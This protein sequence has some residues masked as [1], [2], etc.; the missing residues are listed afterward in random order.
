MAV[1]PRKDRLLRPAERHRNPLRSVPDALI[2]C[3]KAGSST[4]Y[5]RPLTVALCL[6][7]Q[8][9][10]AGPADNELPTNGQIVSGD[11]AISQSGAAMT[12]LQNSQKMI[13]DWDT[14]NIGAGASVT[15]RQPDSSAVALN[16]VTTMGASHI[17]G[18]LNANG[19][20]FLV[21]PSGVTFAPGSRVDVGGITASSLNITD[22][23]F[24]TKSFIFTGDETSGEVLNQGEISAGYV[25]LI[26]PRVINEGRIVTAEGVTALGAGDQ[27]S[28]D[29]DGDQLIRLTVERSTVETLAAN[30]SLIRA[31]NGTVFMNAGARNSL[32]QAVVNNEGVI[33][34]KGIVSEGGR[35]LLSA[36][37]TAG[38]ANVSGVLD[39]SSATDKGGRI[40]VTGENTTLEST[41]RLLADGAT[42]GGDVL[43]GGSWQNSDSSVAQ[44]Q[45][46]IIKKGAVLDASAT[47]VGDGGTVV[48]WSDIHDEESA[49]FAHGTFKA[50]GGANG[51]DGGRI[52][53][54]GYYLS[55]TGIDLSA[56]APT[57]E[58]RGG[59]WLLDPYSLKVNNGGT[60]AGD[61]ALPDYTS[62]G[63]G[64]VI[65]RDDIEAQLDTGTSVTLQTGGT[66]GDG[67]GSGA[68]AIESSITKNSG[69]EATLRLNAHGSITIDSR[70]SSNS[71]ALN[72]YLNS[73]IEDGSGKI[74]LRAFGSV[75]TNG[76]YFYAYGGS[77]GTG[78][79]TGS[80]AASTVGF[81]MSNNRMISTDGGDVTIMGQGWAGGGLGILL[82]DGTAIDAG[83]GDIQLS[84]IGVD[85]GMG[86]SLEAMTI[87]TSG[88]GKITLTGSHT[89]GSG[90]AVSFDGT[91]IT[92]VSGDI[93]L[94]ADSYDFAT[95][96]TITSTAGDLIIATNNTSTMIGINDAGQILNLQ[97]TDLSNVSVASVQVGNSSNT[98]GIS[99][100]GATT[101]ANNLSLVTGGNIAIDGSLDVGSNE[102]AMTTGGN[103]TQTAAVTAAGL[104]LSGGG[105]YTLTDAANNVDTLAADSATTLTYV[106][107][108]GVTVGTVAGTEGVTASGDV[109][110][111]TQA[112]NI[113]LE[114]SVATS[115]TTASALTIHA[116]TTAAALTSTGGDVISSGGTVSV[117]D[118]G[119]GIIYTGSIGGSSALA[120][121]GNFRYSTDENHGNFSK[122]LG[123]GGTY[124]LYREQPS[125]TI[126]PTGYESYEGSAPTPSQ[127]TA[128]AAYNG[129]ILDTGNTSASIET[130]GTAASRP[131]EVF[132]LTVSG[133]APNSYNSLGYYIT[134][135][136][137]NINGHSI[138]ANPNHDQGTDAGK[139]VRDQGNGLADPFQLPEARMSPDNTLIASS[140]YENSTVVLLDGK[141]GLSVGSV[142]NEPTPVQVVVFRSGAAPVSE[143]GFAVQENSQ[144]VRLEPI[145]LKDRGFLLPGDISETLA[146]NVADLQGVRSGFVAKIT[147]GGVIIV[148][149]NARSRTLAD[150]RR[151]LVIQT[152]LLELREQ[153][154][155]NI[156]S[157]RTVY[158]DLQE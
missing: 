123:S 154:E 129:D 96:P 17:H 94:K 73:G 44:A 132:D 58:G 86:V 125:V 33:E 46:T 157:L 158:I 61:T 137:T 100:G 144:S 15:F 102:L 14:F 76:G 148:P 2:Y 1:S 10:L 53:T 57:S 128:S 84:G 151:D 109:N 5:V 143:K 120:D 97:S 92:T 38:E 8:P 31:E 114:K 155:L 135:A 37:G 20:V 34:A 85:N 25:A 142:L 70:I 121:T 35:I 27:V 30:R 118:G 91:T 89:G 67:K 98:G 19:Q 65:D 127:S 6:V 28:L 130:L 47:D 104:K 50:E 48:A 75:A 64:T 56:S 39:V 7:S 110:I 107:A 111:S 156:S 116:G 150:G 101:L 131:G 140:V 18:S 133:L 103:V 82:G 95:S 108:D 66:D 115:G 60:T 11:G 106:N 43:V 80:S 81:Q 134:G 149:D 146:F 88:A 3:L 4:F 72:V 55:T 26:A 22:S 24:L 141:S 23:D 136:A 71:G 145:D 42:A 119:R 9:L 99:V 153:L 147:E 117:G 138:I 40:V 124:Q 45:K 152:A 21:N 69:N 87:K 122:A 16:R 113:T 12:V 79:S 105:S 90:K 93:T 63:G 112:G 41:A 77:S 49:T 68:I 139:G 36:G 29:F 32:A 62:G 13:T 52:E 78:Y 54:S 74:F 83:G 51:G 126:T 59:E